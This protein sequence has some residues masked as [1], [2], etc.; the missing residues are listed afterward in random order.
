MSAVSIW[1]QDLN[2]DDD[3]EYIVR[4]IGQLV[5]VSLETVRLVLELSS[6]ALLPAGYLQQQ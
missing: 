5:T 2:P 1:H 6:L 3:P 4:L